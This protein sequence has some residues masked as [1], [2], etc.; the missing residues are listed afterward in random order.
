[1]IRYLL[2][3]A[4]LAFACAA[5]AQTTTTNDQIDILNTPAGNAKLFAFDYGVPTSPAIELAGLG[6]DKINTS[7]AL[8]PFVLQLPGL[9]NGTTDT[10]ALDFSPAALY[11][12][13]SSV[14]KDYW[15]ESNLY[16]GRVLNRARVGVVL[17]R[18]DNG[19][20]D[21]SKVK[22][23]RIAAGLSVSLFS[24]SD[25]ALT[26]TDGWWSSKVE[27]T[28]WGSCLGTEDNLAILRVS[29]N[30][31]APVD[32]TITHLLFV[33]NRKPNVT[34]FSSVERSQLDNVEDNLDATVSPTDRAARE[35]ERERRP[36]AAD[37]LHYD[38]SLLSSSND[39]G[40][41]AAGDTKAAAVIT[42]C[43][44]RASA[45][46]EHAADLQ[47]GAGAVM[48]G[49]PGAF[50]DFDDTAAAL[51]ASLRLPLRPIPSAAL[52][53]N[54]LY[55]YCT[56]TYR[57][58]FSEMLISCWMIGGSGRAS[59]GEMVQ[60][61]DA[62]LSVFKANVLEGWFGLERVSTA[63][64]IGGYVGFIDQSAV[65]ASEN[66]YN[67]RGWRYYL[68]AAIPLSGIPG[69]DG[70]LEGTWLEASYGAAHGSVTTL[71][72]KVAML[73]I[74][75]APPSLGSSFVAKK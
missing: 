20:G 66:A 30:P 33:A 4:A 38:R 6:G 51:W 41:D 53:P 15:S 14:S 29:R 67:K 70:A 48:S 64:K 69:F 71:D 3:V 61:G 42:D 73:T 18:G 12:A 36:L 19:G 45:A 37:R 11:Q 44:K 39:F 35:A 22:P 27:N 31:T 17:Y 24:S 56:D 52:D 58:K 34:D 72:D 74:S 16:I 47:F 54:K 57:P 62:A 21:Q 63:S 10:V 25:P 32:G 23:S 13:S 60:T 26:S 68:S 49:K 46:A 1:M 28:V 7:T 59:F 65:H 75:F 2:A 9:L 8:K 40:H 5:H 55:D 50:S 43:T